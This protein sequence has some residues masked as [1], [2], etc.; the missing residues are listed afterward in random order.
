MATPV[1]AAVE[2]A[3][4]R[5]NLTPDELVL[6]GLSGGVDS[7]ALTHALST[8]HQRGAGTRLLAVHVNHQI[9]PEST[10]DAARVAKLAETLH[11][12][13]EVIPVDVAGWT[14]VLRQGIEAAARAARYAAF[15]SVAQ[16]LGT[17]WIALGH[18]R[19][20][21]AETVLL[22]LARG[23]S[24]EGLA[25]M[26]WLSERAVPLAPRDDGTVG[27]S[28]IRPLLGIS[29]Q[30]VEQYARANNLEPVEDISNLSLAYR[31]NVVRHHVLPALEAAVPGAVASIARTA[32][33]LQ[34]D[35]DYL[36]SQAV[37][38]EH[39]IIQEKAGLVMI[40]REPARRLHPA[41]QR[42]IMAAAII[43][44]AGTQ[45]PLSFDRIEALRGAVQGGAVSSRIELGNRFTAYVDYETVAIGREMAV[46]DRLRRVSG[47]P[48]ME[49]GTV[50]P[51]D[52]PVD[53]ALGNNWRVRAE[54]GGA[55]THWVLRTRQPG[56]RMQVGDRHSI[57][58][59]DWFV[60]QKI[61]VYVRDWLPLLSDGNVVRWVGGI[62][63]LD[64]EGAASGVRVRLWHDDDRG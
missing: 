27:L 3:V 60:N 4:R 21:Q 63:P 5:A 49:P 34:D 24:L 28:V 33:I 36:D 54:P 52:E 35:A 59:Q 32:A 22:R 37:E 8:L 26:R 48:L 23:T 51:L 10:V 38:A 13:V 17:R 61:P 9:R 40:Q 43:R 41:I 31:R 14:R 30:E 7:L 11:V 12:P 50:V 44:A 25:G 53:L 64:F 1:F 20:D 55:G 56:D 46:E 29:R 39:G 18:T 47:L 19:D 57:R 62:S 6:I 42:R 2:S 16:R 15:G 45:A 58:L